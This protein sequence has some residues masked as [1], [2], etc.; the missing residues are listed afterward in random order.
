M[1]DNWIC[2]HRRYKYC[3]IFCVDDRPR[4]YLK[5]SKTKYVNQILTLSPAP[6][7]TEF[8][9]PCFSRDCPPVGE[10]AVLYLFFFGNHNI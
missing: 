9:V 7:P 5:P 2:T 10:F 8:L 3:G 1:T 4:F 6:N